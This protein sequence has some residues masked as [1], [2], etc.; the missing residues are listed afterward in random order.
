MQLF[1]FALCSKDSFS[2]C[3]SSPFQQVLSKSADLALVSPL[4]FCW[5]RV[6]MA[7]T[8]CRAFWRCTHTY[9]YFKQ[10]KK[11]EFGKKIPHHWLSETSRRHST[12]A[13]FICYYLQGLLLSIFYPSC[14]QPKPWLS[15]YHT[16]RAHQLSSFIT[17]RLTVNDVSRCCCSDPLASVRVRLTSTLSLLPLLADLF[18]K[19][20]VGTLVA[21]LPHEDLILIMTRRDKLV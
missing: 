6:W 4:L 2:L 21:H 3:S 15:V 11:E 13:T 7:I 19:L 10:A 8:L 20:D 5:W 9:I 16:D 1:S 14:H 18:L 17:L 12:K